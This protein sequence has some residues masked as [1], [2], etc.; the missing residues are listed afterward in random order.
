MIC[1]R[2]TTLDSVV[3]HYS[4]AWSHYQDKKIINPHD[5]CGDYVFE[6][7]ELSIS[8]INNGRLVALT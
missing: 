2:I 4:S 5:F 1:R 7:N 6:R 8:E 3:S